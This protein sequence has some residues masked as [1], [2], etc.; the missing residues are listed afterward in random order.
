MPSESLVMVIP[1]FVCRVMDLIG[2]EAGDPD[3]GLVTIGS[4]DGA[5]ICQNLTNLSI[6]AE[7]RVVG[8]EN[9]REVILLIWPMK[10]STRWGSELVISQI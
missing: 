10:V 3:S 8:E 2:A 7:M 6:D 5:P 4:I 9:V 1:S